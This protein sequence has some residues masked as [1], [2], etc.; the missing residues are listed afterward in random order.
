VVISVR[1]WL[2]VVALVALAAA[3]GFPSAP[4]PLVAVFAILYG[5][6]AL[7][8]ARRRSWGR[9]MAIGLGAVGIGFLP[10][11]AI[12]PRL[13]EG[14]GW[15]L[16]SAI[17]AIPAALLAG[18]SMRSAFV[19][20]LAPRIEWLVGASA[21]ALAWLALLMNDEAAP[22]LAVAAIAALGA[23]IAAAVHARAWSVL[24]IALG[25]E[26]ALVGFASQIATHVR[27]MD[28]YPIAMAAVCA[29]IGL[30]PFVMPVARFLLTDRP[31]GSP[32]TPL[33]A[34]APSA[35]VALFLLADLLVVLAALQSV[36]G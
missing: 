25:A 1:R 33:P 23:G 32:R 2:A 34:I 8:V 35:L 13:L 12:E 9:A 11:V 30:A 19:A 27:L 14:G 16:V 18:R 26:A 29:T 28:T 7:G 21:C 3:G 31:I 36:I 4:R 5:A 24:A 6:A 20:P 22:W 15:L 10:L 17:L